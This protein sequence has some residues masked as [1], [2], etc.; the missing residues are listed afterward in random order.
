MLISKKNIVKKPENKVAV[1]YRNSSVGNAIAK[2]FAREGAR[3]FLTGNVLTKHDSIADEILCGGGAI[4]KAQLK[5]LDELTVEKHMNVVIKKTRKV[6]ISFNP[7]GIPKKGIQGIIV[8]ELSADSFSLPTTTST[9]S[10]FVTDRSAAHHMVK[11][12]CEILLPENFQK[13]QIDM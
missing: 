9:Q 7:I 12:R 2:A 8:T 6:D 11:Q 4:E 3:V 13:L 5:A 10:H 1:I